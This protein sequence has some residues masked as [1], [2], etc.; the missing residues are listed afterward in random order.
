MLDTT[1]AISAYQGMATT[2]ARSSLTITG[3]TASSASA[4]TDTADVSALAR[5]M[6]DRINRLD[7][8]ACIYPGNDVRQT[9]KSLAEV[10][11]DFLSDFSAYAA[12]FAE[13]SA[14]M[15]LDASASFTMG[16]DGVGGV[17]VTGSDATAAASLQRGYTAN[18]TLVSRFALMAARAALTD[19]GSTIDGFQD[20]YAQD[21]VAAIGDNIDALKDRLLG[22]RTVSAGGSMHYGFVRDGAADVDI[23]DSV[24]P[25]GAAA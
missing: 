17:T 10:E 4:A 7:V 20:A 18:S 9:S 5:E 22:F 2:T 12:A 25:S 3:G 13:M 11:S 23:V 8:F 24:Q 6:L 21:P 16:L 1:A 14:L 19:A 15:G